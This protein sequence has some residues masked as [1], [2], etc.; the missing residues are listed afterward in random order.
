MPQPMTSTAVRAILG[1]DTEEVFVV[2][3]EIDHADMTTPLRVALNTEDVTSN[4]NLFTAF[5]FTI[6]PPSDESD[7]INAGRIVFIDVTRE[8]RTELL[9]ISSPPTVDAQV[10]L[11]SDPNS[12]QI[13]WPKLLLNDL[14]V[15]GIQISGQLVIEDFSK[16][17][18]P[19]AIMSPGRFPGLHG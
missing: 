9:S 2:L 18:F 12:I 11:A 17:P 4:G 19:A 15:E 13:Q 3:L 1:Q 16:E 8:I 5:P 6:I 14:I 10:V 7:R